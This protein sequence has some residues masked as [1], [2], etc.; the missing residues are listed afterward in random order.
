LDTIKLKS[1]KKSLSY[2]HEKYIG[3]KFINLADKIS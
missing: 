3:H 2:S 1:H